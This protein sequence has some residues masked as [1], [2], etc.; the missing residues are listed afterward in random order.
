MYLDG[1]ASASEDDFSDISAASNRVDARQ[2]IRKSL[3]NFQNLVHLGPDGFAFLSSA[4]TNSQLPVVD[5]PVLCRS[6]AIVV[7]NNPALLVGRRA[8]DI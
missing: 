4:A 1:Q 5:F 2:R 7:S 6:R 8:R 3:A